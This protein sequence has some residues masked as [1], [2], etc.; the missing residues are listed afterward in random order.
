MEETNN[1]VAQLQEQL[2]SEEKQ[3]DIK[4]F[5]FNFVVRFWYLY[6]VCI[7]LAFIGTNFYAWYAT[8]IYESTCSV[9][10]KSQK[11]AATGADILKEIDDFTTERNIQ[12]EIEILK[13][14]N[15][16]SKTV[17]SLNLGV[18]YFL[19]GTFKT[20]ELYLDSPFKVEIDSLKYL[21]YN[22]PIEI[23]ILDDKY[24]SLIFEN[25]KTEEEIIEKKRF[26]ERVSGLLG[27]FTIEKTD[28]FIAANYNNSKYDKRNFI[29]DFH[30][31]ENMINRYRNGLSIDLANKQSSILEM[32]YQDRV[33]EKATDFLNKL[34][35][36]WQQNSIEQKNEMA[37]NS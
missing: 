20:T 17:E 26:G 24:Y 9:L 37:Q 2:E 27:T 25:P 13:S 3:F 31:L 6:L 15:L 11:S 23:R 32:T 35:E 5:F 18:S 33:P 22:A 12:N 4:Y 28:Y 14:R 8:P 21:A 1:N 29:V 30:T 7:I 34:M 19:K 10:I 36:V 16:I